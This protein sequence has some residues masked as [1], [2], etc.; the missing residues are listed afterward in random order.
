MSIRIIEIFVRLRKILT[1]NIEL[2]L[3]IEKVQKKT[4][5]NTKNIEFVFQY[6]DEL[7]ETK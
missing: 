7:I 2:R 3:A 5:N 4:E 1:D 6:L